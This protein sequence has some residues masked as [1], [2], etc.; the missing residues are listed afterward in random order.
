MKILNLAFLSSPAVV[1]LALLPATLARRTPFH[2]SGRDPSMPSARKVVPFLWFGRDAEAALRFYATIFPDAKI[3]DEVRWGEGGPEPKGTLM[4]ARIQ[5]AGQ[6][7]M[8]LNGGPAPKFNDSFSVFVHADTQA[9]IDELWA[10]LTADGGEPGPCGWLK[11]KFG[12]SWQVVP[13]RLLTMLSDKDGERVKHVG[14]ALMQM[15]KIDLARL[16]Q[17]YAGR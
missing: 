3:G 14:G 17:A 13:T 7:F 1:V 5:L 9:E 6:E 11:D 8:V 2:Q 10:K 4:A 12:L 16:E 15:K